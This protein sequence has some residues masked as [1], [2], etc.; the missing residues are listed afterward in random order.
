M[1]QQVPDHRPNLCSFKF[2][3]AKSSRLFLTGLIIAASVE[4]INPAMVDT[5]SCPLFVSCTDGNSSG[6]VLSTESFCWKRYIGYALFLAPGWQ[7]DTSN[8]STHRYSS[9]ITST[10]YSWVNH[11]STEE[12]DY[13]KIGR[14]VSTVFIYVASAGQDLYISRATTVLPAIN[15]F[16]VIGL[17]LLLALALF[18]PGVLQSSAGI[19]GSLLGGL[20]YLIALPIWGTSSGSCSVHSLTG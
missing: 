17:L 6:T 12:R 18:G 2:S 7:A 4:S 15:S 19:A 16:R 1:W 20:F 11:H 9:Y 14:G 8:N 5:I 10:Q 3:S 13:L